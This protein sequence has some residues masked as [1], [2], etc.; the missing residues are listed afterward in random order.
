[1]VGSRV[2]EMWIT[3]FMEERLGSRRNYQKEIC[4]FFVDKLG[5]W[6]P[7]CCFTIG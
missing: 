7:E 1:M 5:T 6:H 4:T 2:D 3:F